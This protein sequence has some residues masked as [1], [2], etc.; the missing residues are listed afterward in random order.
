MIDSLNRL[1]LL[2]W[3]KHLQGSY[4]RR[5]GRSAVPFIT[6]TGRT[7][8]APVRSDGNLV[9]QVVDVGALTGLIDV[10]GTPISYTV[11]MEIYMKPGCSDQITILLKDIFTLCKTPQEAFCPGDKHNFCLLH[12]IVCEPFICEDMCA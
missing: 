7:A 3:R 6:G 1:N 2:E 12:D 8:F 5:D 10:N 11:D 9:R 4:T